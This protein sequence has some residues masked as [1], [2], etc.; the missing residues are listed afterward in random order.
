MTTSLLPGGDTIND[1]FDELGQQAGG[2]GVGLALE[3]LGL[4]N[5]IST[6]KCILPYGATQQMCSAFSLPKLPQEVTCVINNR[7]LGIQCCL[8]VD[9]TVAH[10]TTQTWL[11]IDPCNFQ[12]SVGFGSWY[13]NITLITYQWGQE[14]GHTLGNNAVIIRFSVDKLD[15]T[16]EFQVNLQV[17][18]HI[19]DE[20]SSI[21][22][23]VDTRLPIPLCNTE[24]SFSDLGVNSITEL[25]E[26][27]GGNIAQAG[28]DWALSELG[29]KEYITGNLCTIP[30][31]QNTCPAPSLPT[32]QDILVCAI[33]EH[34]LGIQCCV[35]L[36]FRVTQLML[37]AWLII[38][39]CDFQFSIGFENF[40]LNFTLFAY[41]WG[42]HEQIKIADIWRSGVPNTYFVDENIQLFH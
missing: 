16:K 34:C 41:E 6:D 22:I 33:D 1:F 24:F 12:I 42:K 7:C 26:S 32:N 36:D 27:F 40:D 8:N 5:F 19:D 17:E 11:I 25:A 18:I 10:L 14:E 35:N 39:P 38:D 9:I 37:K 20:S 2:A 4:S 31:G 3:Y 29:I 15:A 21:P 13:L 30:T 28:I 23:L